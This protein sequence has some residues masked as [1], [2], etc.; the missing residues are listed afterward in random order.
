MSSAGE[1]IVRIA[2]RQVRAVCVVRRIAFFGGGY[3]IGEAGNV[4]FCER[5][6]EVDSAGVASRL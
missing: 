5:R 6:K 1:N 2:D 3:Y 4:V